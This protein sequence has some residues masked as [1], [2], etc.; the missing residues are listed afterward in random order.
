MFDTTV[1]AIATTL[2]AIG[3]GGLIVGEIRSSRAQLGGIGSEL[4]WT[5]LWMAGLTVLLISAW[6]RR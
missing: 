6:A 2:A 3:L 5:V 1:L 4:K